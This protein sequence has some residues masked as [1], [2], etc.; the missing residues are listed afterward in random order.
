MAQWYQMGQDKDFPPPGIGMPA[1][2]AVPYTPIDAR[3]ASSKPILFAGA[4][5]GHVLVKNINNA[6]PLKEPRML[7]IFG[8]SAKTPD[9]NNIG[10]NSAWIY[11]G[12][13]YA[14][15]SE[16][17]GTGFDPN[18]QAP[19]AMNGTMYSGGGS[20]ATSQSLLSSP[21]DAITQQCWEDDTAMFWDFA[22]SDPLV[23]ATSSACLV[24]G[25]AWATEGFDRPSVRDDYTD[26]LVKNVASACNNTIVIFHNAG[27]RLVDQWIDHPNITAV[28]YA[29]LPG[30]YSGKALV[31]ILYGKENPSGKLPYTVAK[32]ESDY[33]G[34]FEPAQPEG[35][36]GLFPQS[37][38]TEGVFTDYRRF[39]YMNITPRYEFGFGMSY[40]T[41][42]YSGLQVTKNACANTATYPTGPVMQGGQTD[43]WDVV[44]SANATVE[45]TGTM[46]G[47][48]TA[49]LYVAMPGAG[50]NMV[51]VKQLRGFDKKFL[52]A[53]QS[54]TFSFDLTRRDLSTWDVMAQKW[55]LQD[56]T[57]KV[58]VGSS[59]LNLPLTGS[60]TI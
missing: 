47:M 51:P 5:E 33:G 1:N 4:V 12:E 36:F 29:H 56:G 39:D 52:N 30:Q 27:V 2:V 35:I 3:K 10:S 26:A 19:I 40:T 58:M 57:Y 43:L 54:T 23:E 7:S 8:Y 18:M 44:V 14:P 42:S 53:S 49:Q 25:N 9:S 59:S 24:I 41:F 48:E 15:P 55:K 21:M 50:A 38:F 37:N 60:F 13:P 32:N 6:L 16:L 11:G 28:I 46:G 17:V 31:S 45:N 20:G 22:N 34:L